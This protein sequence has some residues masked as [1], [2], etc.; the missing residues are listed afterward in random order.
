M[1][2]RTSFQ[3]QRRI[4]EAVHRAVCEFTGTDGFGH[5]LCYAVCGSVVASTMLE[6]LYLP[7]AGTVCIFA[8]PPN[9]VAMQAT[10]NGLERG[11]FHCW[12]GLP[13]SRNHGRGKRLAEF[14]DLTSRHYKRY[15]SEVVCIEEAVVSDGCRTYMLAPEK[16]RIRWTR[17]DD[18]PQF[19][20]TNGKFPDLMQAVPDEAACLRLFEIVN[21]SMSDLD[22]LCS[23]AFK[24]LGLS[25][26]DSTSVI[27]EMVTPS[28]VPAPITHARVGRNQPCPCGSGRKFKKCCRVLINS[29]A[30]SVRDDD[31]R[32][33]HDGLVSASQRRKRS[34]QEEEQHFQFVPMKG[35]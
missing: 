33:S 29:H 12:F 2:D 34:D 16:D 19:I 15:V 18:P 32:P 10:D 6:K 28:V 20:W 14:V 5:C 21:D 22:D 3:T 27:R 35:G 13:E 30:R 17:T 24:Y 7:Q 11:E 1:E 8:D 31:F 23:L 4:S 25:G 9:A 26:F